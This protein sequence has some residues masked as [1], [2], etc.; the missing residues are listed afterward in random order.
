M[1]SW[2]AP[3][4]LPDAQGAVPLGDRPE[5]RR[6]EARRRSRATP[7]GRSRA[8]SA[9]QPARQL[10]APQMPNA[11]VIGSPRLDRPVAGAEQPEPRPRPGREHQVARER[12]PV[13]AAGAGLPPPRSCRAAARAAARRHAVATS[14]VAACSNAASWSTSLITRRPSAGSISRSFAFS[15]SADPPD[16]RAELVH[17]EGGHLHPRPVRERLPAERRRPGCHARSPPPPGSRAAAATGRAAGSGRLKS[18]NRL[19]AHR[20]AA[21]RRPSP[22]LVARRGSRAGRRARRPA[23]PP[24]TAGRTRS[25]TRGWRCA[26]GPRRRR[27]GRIPRASARARGARPPAPRTA[28]AG[29]SGRGPG[30]PKS[31]RSTV[32]SRAVRH[33]RS[34]SS[35]RRAAST[36][37]PR[38]RRARC[39]TNRSAGDASATARS[40]SGQVTRTSASV[41]GPSPTCVQPSWPPMWPPP[42]TTSRRPMTVS[43]TRISTTAPIA[44]RLPP[45]WRSRYAEPVAHRRRRVGRP[46][47]DVAPH[48]RPAHRG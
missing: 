8:S 47:A 18:W 36:G 44:S 27:G 15:T 12:R 38:P 26:R 21:R 11:T 4:G 34:S 22:A 41:A 32:A 30:T 3:P 14:G 40:P 17:D 48:A 24:R 37:R 5:V 28:S 20:R 35:A 31:G 10:S 29:S 25:G 42:T 23:S 46:R 39:R 7:S 16:E 6:D 43:P 33:R 1:I 45:G 9:T 13:P 2:S 19:A